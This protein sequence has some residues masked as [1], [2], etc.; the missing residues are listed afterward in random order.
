MVNLFADMGVQPQTL[1][2]S[3]KL[4]QQSTDHTPPVAVITT[5]TGGQNYTV[6]QNVTITGTASDVGGIVAGVEVSTDG[7][8]TW[9]PATGTTNWSYNWTASGSGSVVIEARAIDDSVN[10]QTTPAAV[11]VN[12]PT[13]APWTGLFTASNTPALTNANDGK[14]LEVGVKFTSSVAGSITGIEFYRATGDTGPDIAQLWSSTGTLLASGTFSN[15]STFGWQTVTFSSPVAITAG[16]TYVASYHSTGAYA[17]TTNYFATAYTNGSL[18]APASA[19]VYAYGGTS[20]S[21]IFPTKTYQANNY[22]VD[23]VFNNGGANLPPVANADSGFVTPEN[24]PLTITTSSLLA[25]DTDP[26]GYALSVTSVAPIAGTTLGTVGLSGSTITYTPPSATFTGADSFAYTISDGHGGTA[27]AT[28]AL[29][30]AAPA[31]TQSLFSASNT[32]ALTN[33]NDG[34]QL[35]V[36]V[37]F[38]SSVAGSITGIEFYRATGDT[39][40]DIA[41]LW[42]STG[43]LLASGT[44]SNTSAS[45]WQT[46]TFSSPVAITAGTTY[47]ASY[48]STGA[49]ADT[50]N[51]FTT[52]HTNGSLT[53]PASAGVYAYGGT[54]TSGIF[55]TK[56][57]QANNYWVDVVFNNG[58]ANLPPVA[59]ADSG[60]VT[61][62]NTPLT[63]TTSSLLANDTDPQGYA[64]S[65]TSV[66]PI[67][68]TTL[69]TVGL[70]GSTITYTPPSATF[71]GA[72]SFAY[73]ISDGHGGTASTAVALNVAAPPVANADSGFVTP[74]N[75][76]LTITTSSLLANDTDP[77]GYALSVTSVA[78]IAGTT[79]GTV[80]LSGSTITYTPPSATFTG[81]DSFAYTISDGHGGTASAT[82]ALNVAAPAAT[83]SLFSASNTPALTNANDKKQLEVGVKFTSSVAGSITGI[84]FYR[85]TGDT[86][87]DIAQL[88]SSTGTL[89]ASGT[90]SNTS[91]SGWQTVTFSSPVAITAGTTYVAS[92]HST[93]AYAD[94][95][96]YFTTAH[97]NGSLT[98][99]ASAGVYAY[100]GTSTSG[101]FPTKTYQASNYWVDVVFNPQLTS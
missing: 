100:G 86:G 26:Q 99:P 84:E 8:K 29:N 64:L 16:T 13:I 40:P 39:G 43:T 7:G 45:G 66:A 92:Y 65:V 24:T 48:H 32:P 18:T 34:K 101:I 22:W 70:S 17:D 75:T 56:T 25:N 81:A 33:A 79:L 93:G 97:T 88:W 96:N 72:D 4:A 23:V 80:G 82:V 41:Q 47:V 77:Q 71:T 89:L 61:P 21:G 51:Y 3:L 59:N 49:Y 12:L 9:N 5:P 90:F 60:F 76:P 68:G 44:F 31:A 50:T 54:S 83:Q 74:E 6:G 62:E 69:G 55:P 87:P 91:A 94:T 78:P 52:A 98:A 20:T 42:S 36:G 11:N 38:T 27:S 30:V 58:G 28:V 85:A 67:A 19:G 15:T 37:K 10:V 14:Q 63:I 46:V 57:Y 73:T 35:E 1:L 53:A 2:A 95:T